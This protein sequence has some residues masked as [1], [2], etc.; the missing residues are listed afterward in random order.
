MKISELEKILAEYREQLGDVEV[1]LDA[2]GERTPATFE[3]GVSKL[4]VG[5][6]EDH[7]MAVCLNVDTDDSTFLDDYATFSMWYE[8]E[9]V[10]WVVDGQVVED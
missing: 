1:Y 5:T 8:E 4:A 7:V 9:D 10:T 2:G 6:K 3:Y